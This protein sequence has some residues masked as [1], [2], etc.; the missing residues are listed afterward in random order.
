MEKL[1][2]FSNTRAIKDFFERNYNA[3]FLPNAQ[4]IGEFFDS[5]LRVEAKI[6][7]IVIKKQEIGLLLRIITLVLS[8]L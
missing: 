7:I 1:Y 3:S 6:Q 4:S 8:Y 2:L 5:I